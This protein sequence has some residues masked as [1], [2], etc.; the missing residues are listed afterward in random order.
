MSDYGPEDFARKVEGTKADRL[1]AEAEQ[2]A[3][4]VATERRLGKAK[5]LL[6]LSE[7]LGERALKDI[8]VIRL[9]E[10]REVP[11]EVREE[12]K[13]GFWGALVG[14]ERKADVDPPALPEPAG[15]PI[16]GLVVHPYEPSYSRSSSGDQSMGALYGPPEVVPGRAGLALTVEGFRT[17]SPREAS[18]GMVNKIGHAVEPTPELVYPP[19]L[20]R[21]VNKLEGDLAEIVS[22]Q[23]DSGMQQTAEGARDVEE[24]TTSSQPPNLLKELG[25]SIKSLDDVSRLPRDRSGEIATEYLGSPID[26]HHQSE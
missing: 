15:E 16:L 4:D 2:Q 17:Y 3:Q 10:L 1:R 9:Y 25:I 5:W 24:T 23:P 7:R 13:V 8:G 22:Q 11:R 6:E 21:L 26:P 12:T 19:L 14:R 20:E 18:I